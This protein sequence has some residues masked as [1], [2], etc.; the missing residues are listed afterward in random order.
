[1]NRWLA[2]KPVRRTLQ[3][4]AALLGLLVRG[5][6]RRGLHQWARI[7]VRQASDL[8][9][10]KRGATVRKPASGE[11]GL[12]ATVR[13]ICR[14]TGVGLRALRDHLPWRQ[15]GGSL[16]LV[17]S[18]A[19]LSWLAP[20]MLNQ[21]DRPIDA[22]SVRGDFKGLDV[23]DIEES[24]Q[25]LIGKS[26]FATDLLQL[27]A[28]LEALPWVDS[29]AI[30]RKW[31][32]V[33][34]VQV[35]EQQPVAYWNATSLIT[36]KGVVFTPKNRIALPGLPALS[37]PPSRAQSVLRQAGDLSAKLAPLGVGLAALKTEARGAW[38][39]TLTNGIEVALGRDQLEQRFANFLTVYQKELMQ[40]A[41]QVAQVDAR[42]ANGVAI[43]WKPDVAT[44]AKPAS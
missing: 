36:G 7:R 26:F 33:L 1:M 40:R 13:D 41:D 18:L 29:V 39:L 6:H 42:Y 27:K 43:R 34:V 17:A 20:A 14:I 10:R 44:L 16:L 23:A 32:G 4:W 3:G 37:G 21:L 35:D 25:P 31:P 28:Q 5:S 38:T 30:R 22:I 11:A 15:I 24:L 19:G 2:S 8:P 9:P 12:F